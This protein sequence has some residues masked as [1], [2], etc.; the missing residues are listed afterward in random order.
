MF[1]SLHCSSDLILTDLIKLHKNTGY[2]NASNEFLFQGG[3]VKVKV[4]VAIFFRY[5][6]LFFFDMVHLVLA[7]I[8]FL[9]LLQN[10][11]TMN[12]LTQEV[13]KGYGGIVRPTYTR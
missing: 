10:Q 4:T 3:R 1:Y 7:D 2:D 13:C 5:F 9:C 12:N 11:V 8:L 6:Q